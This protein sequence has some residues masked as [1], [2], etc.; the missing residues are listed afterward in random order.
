V[1]KRTAGKSGCRFPFSIQQPAE[2]F[3][4]SRHGVDAILESQPGRG[5]ETEKLVCCPAFGQWLP[6][7]KRMFI[8]LLVVIGGIL[9]GQAVNALL[10]HEPV[11]QGRRL[12][13]WLEDLDPVQPK[14]VRARARDAIRQ[15]GTNAVPMLMDWF[16]A[17]DSWL[18]IRL[19]ELANKQRLVKI[20]FTSAPDRSRRAYRACRILG[21]RAK[22]AIPGL[23][24]LLSDTR[25]TPTAGNVLV[26]FGADAIGPLTQALT[27][28]S[29]NIRYSAACLL[30]LFRAG[31]VAAVPA[32]IQSLKDAD[33]RMRL[34][35]AL[36]LDEIHEAPGAV[37][38]AL[39]TNLDDPDAFVRR[40][41]AE[42]LGRFGQQAKPAVPALMKGM[43]DEVD[44][45]RRAAADALRQIDPQS[46][47]RAEPATPTVPAAP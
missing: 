26:L 7:K 30:G 19:I 23:I 43:N 24:E 4:L 18:K 10:P 36:S 17:R 28:Q 21:P 45:V 40:V 20:H 6:M 41:T 34:V 11:Y 33:Y 13:A 14:E 22:P 27:N 38:P 5:V 8:G 37:V 32:L 44:S 29:I 3:R 31:A 16:R 9:A 39:I 2:R 15:I 47:T 35:A 12:S 25:T 46:A 42:A 1:V